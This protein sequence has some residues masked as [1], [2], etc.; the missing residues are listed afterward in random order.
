MS[1][2]ARCRGPNESA[3]IPGSSAYVL[4]AIGQRTL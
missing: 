2:A 3:F 1:T 4:L